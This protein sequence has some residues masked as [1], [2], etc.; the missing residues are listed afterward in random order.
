MKY[1]TFP[2]L[3]GKNAA[4]SATTAV[5]ML[6]VYQENSTPYYMCLLHAESTIWFKK[7]VAVQSAHLA[8][9]YYC[10]PTR[11]YTL[12]YPVSMCHN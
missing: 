10:P 9:V 12:I 4:G 8:A 1:V 7:Y 11:P 3:V 5:V 6:V 2:L